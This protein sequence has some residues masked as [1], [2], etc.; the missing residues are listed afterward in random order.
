MKHTQHLMKATVDTKHH[1]YEV[2]VD[3]YSGNRYKVIAG[4]SF[5]IGREYQYGHGLRNRRKLSQEET[6]RYS[7]G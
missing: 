4:E 2:I 5:L 7:L 1:S 3:K 6:A